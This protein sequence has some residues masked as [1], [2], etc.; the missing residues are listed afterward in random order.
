MTNPIL[1][2]DN[3]NSFV[4]NVAR[5]FEELGQDVRVLRNDA[6]DIAGIRKL[7]RRRLSSF[8]PVPARRAMRAFRRRSFMS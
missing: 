1:V 6:I 2:I 4:F 8:R 3:Y 7:S 5:Y